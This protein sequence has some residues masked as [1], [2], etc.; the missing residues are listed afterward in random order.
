MLH[1]VELMSKKERK[2]FFT[3]ME[4]ELT[5]YGGELFVDEDA[6]MV[7]A[8]RPDSLY[9][10]C[11]M[12]RV[13]IAYC[14]AK[15]K[16]KKKIGGIIAMQRLMWDGEWIKIRRENIYDQSRLHVMIGIADDLFDV[17]NS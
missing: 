16:F 17:F 13:A 5:S 6:R 12:Y 15:D 1:S 8:I 3:E 4:A 7:I 11:S 9:G 2:E 14:N 10:N